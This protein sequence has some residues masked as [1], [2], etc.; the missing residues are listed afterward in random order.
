MSKSCSKVVKVFKKLSTNFVA[1][2]K[3]PQKVKSPEKKKNWK[4]KIGI[5][6]TF[7]HFSRFVL[8]FSLF[9]KALDERVIRSS[10]FFW[11]K[12]GP[13]ANYKLFVCFLSHIC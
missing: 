4:Q 10:F 1:L 9:Y 8:D 6:S 7:M 3:T 13:V 5:Q 12:F 11:H 2:G